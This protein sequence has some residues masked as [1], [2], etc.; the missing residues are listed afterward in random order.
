M[1]R[2][3]RRYSDRRMV[4]DMRRISDAEISSL[5]DKAKALIAKIKANLAQAAK[6]NP[7]LFKAIKVLSSV[8]GAIAGASIGGAGAMLALKK[9]NEKLKL[10]ADFLSAAG[11]GPIKIMVLGLISLVSATINWMVV[12]SATSQE[13]EG[14]VGRGG[15]GR[16]FGR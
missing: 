16:G 6:D 5:V 4:M 15:A 11:F 2:V 3:G 1:Y 9:S 7:K 14:G 13:A 8:Q 12:N 10:L